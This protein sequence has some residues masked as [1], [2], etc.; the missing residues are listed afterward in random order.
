MK[1]M[2]I[3]ASDDFENKV[4]KEM[5]KILQSELYEKYDFEKLQNDI[6]RGLILFGETEININNYLKPFSFLLFHICFLFHF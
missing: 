2:F 4:Q 6:M 5:I 1:D 3:F